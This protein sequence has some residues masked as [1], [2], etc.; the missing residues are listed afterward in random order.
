MGKGIAKY[1]YKSGILPVT[2][3]IL[4]KPTT[5]QLDLIAKSKAAQPKGVRGEGYADGVQHP[6]RSSRVPPAPEFIDVETLIKNTV[7]RSHKD[8]QIN[9]V[10]QRQKLERAQVRQRYLE[11][12]FRN[13][14]N[15][16]LRRDELIQRR[17]EIEKLEHERDLKLINQKKSSDL[18]IP[19]LEH[20]INQPLMRQ[21]TEE[22]KKLLD[23]KRKY[24]RDLVEFK[25]REN[26]IRKLLELY[27]V[28]DEF[29][30]TEEQLM[31]K[32]DNLIPIRKLPISEETR[33]NNIE[34]KLGDELFGSINGK[35]GLPMIKEYLNNEAEEFAERIRQQNEQSQQLN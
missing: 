28:A 26:K 13:E 21:R 32:L 23:M 11:E 2:R 1:G 12:A 18:T 22:E 31:K 25:S 33:K 34:N 5:K 30:V 6:P 17:K 16:I 20:I 27:Y 19:S 9:T 7:P 29:I 3:S 24:N 10:E 15:R 14:E 8:L 4:K 35:P